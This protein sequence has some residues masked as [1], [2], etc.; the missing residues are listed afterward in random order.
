MEPESPEPSLLRHLAAQLNLDCDTETQAQSLYSEFQSGLS[1]AKAKTH[2]RCAILLASKTT[3]VSSLD[4]RTVPA[5]YVSIS[6]LLRSPTAPPIQDFVS[7]LLTFS[8]KVSVSEEAKREIRD[9]TH[10]YAFSLKFYRKFEE[11]WTALEVTDRANR[12]DV[13]QKIREMAWLLYLIV[14]Q[15]HLQQSSDVV[16]TTNLL[17]AVLAQ[18]T[19]LFPSSITT[20]VAQEQTLEFLC[21][22]V[23]CRNAVVLTA[24]AQVEALLIQLC[25]QEVI[26]TSSPSK[27]EGLFTSAHIPYNLQKLNQTYSELLTPENIDERDFISTCHKVGT[28]IKQP[29]VLTPFAKHGSAT[30]RPLPSHR[31]IKWDE[32]EAQLNL[33]SNLKDFSVRSLTQQTLMSAVATP[34]TLAMEM[35][36]WLHDLVEMVTVEGVIPRTLVEPLR[37]K[38]KE[39]VVRDVWNTLG[40]ELAV[41]CKE[42]GVG[43]VSARETSFIEQHFSSLTSSMQLLSQEY[44]FSNSK[45]DLIIKLCGVM[46]EKMLI[47]R[48]ELDLN[49]AFLRGLV[50]CST[51]TAFFLHNITAID[52][53]QVLELCRCT[54][55][56]FW[57]VLS[58]FGQVDPRMPIPLRQHL[59]R[60]E[61]KVL[62]STAWTRLLPLTS[63]QSSSNDNFLQRVLSQ[64]AHRLLSLSECLNLP[65][66]I[67]EVAWS[68]T[69]YVL[70]ECTDMLSNR[71]LDQLVLCC[72]FATCKTHGQQVTFNHIN[73]VYGKLNPEEVAQLTKSVQI[74]AGVYDNIIVFYNKVFIPKVKDF[75]AGRVSQSV[76]RVEKLCPKSPLRAN[77]P[78]PA[79]NYVT[80]GLPKVSLSR[81]P[82]SVSPFMTPRTK[83]LYAHRESPIKTANVPKAPHSQRVLQFDEK[84]EGARVP[85]H[86]SHILSPTMSLPFALPLLKPEDKKA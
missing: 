57:N 30:S 59:R 14:R 20:A 39:V 44:L 47:A 21:T 77:L 33:D 23:K 2:V 64:A 58:F 50:A 45:V 13:V 35:N 73:E 24:V 51:E 48:T 60:I 46:L 12:E 25:A 10:R 85:T 56:D 28:P 69:K 17:I 86:L 43:A 62:S 61:V 37:T 3:T 72:L 8:E 42:V 76:T 16:E 40:S 11:L 6:Q 78:A 15:K 41:K 22:Q 81:S 68:T 49:E 53:E 84:E 19:T 26:R 70:S 83:L 71:H 27:L 52:F 75:I 82:M 36:N 79:Q 5:C 1:P 55:I 38:G 4:G 65:E 80:L 67:R 66:D 7:E 54:A 31:V 9:L 34:V 74:D 32:T 29:R 18:V 63:L